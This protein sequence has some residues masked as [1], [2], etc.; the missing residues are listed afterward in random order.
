MGVRC[1]NSFFAFGFKK[2]STPYSHIQFQRVE[3]MIST[4]KIFLRVG[5]TVSTFQEKIKIVNFL[6]IIIKSIFER[7]SKTLI[8][9]IWAIFKKLI[10]SI[11]ER[12]S[13][14]VKSQ[15]LIKKVKSKITG[16]KI[17]YIHIIQKTL[18]KWFSILYYMNFKNKY[19]HESILLK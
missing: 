9:N 18:K 14:K 12:S 2:K 6:K 16:W 3:G 15:K 13:K 8:V 1:W 4:A 10:K 11:F 7:S 17:L 19:S 5:A